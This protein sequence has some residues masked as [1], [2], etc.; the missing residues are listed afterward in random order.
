MCQCAWTEQRRELSTPRQT[1]NAIPCGKNH[2]KHTCVGIVQ[3]SGDGEL[4]RL[5][6]SGETPPRPTTLPVNYHTGR[7]HP[8]A[9]DIREL[10]SCCCLQ[11][12]H[13]IRV[14]SIQEK[15]THTL[16]NPVG[17][18]HSLY[19]C[20]SAESGWEEWLLYRILLPI[21]FAPVTWM[22]VHK[23]R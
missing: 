7:K 12:Q 10:H 22:G 21:C 15:G 9:A 5:C 23:G 2:K 16:C 8:Q 4:F 18:L 6:A 19:C 14:R 3:R 13:N 1:T 11:G 17:T 20:T